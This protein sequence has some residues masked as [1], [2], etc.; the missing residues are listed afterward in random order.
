[1]VHS[2]LANAAL[3]RP[4]SLL[5]RPVPWW[6]PGPIVIIAG[7]ELA[8][9]GGNLRQMLQDLPHGA[10]KNV[11]V[12]MRG[13]K[14]YRLRGEGHMSHVTGQGPHLLVETCKTWSFLEL[15]LHLRLQAKPL[16]T[17]NAKTPSPVILYELTN[18]GSATWLPLSFTRIKSVPSQA[19][20]RACFLDKPEQQKMLSLDGH[21]KQLYID[22]PQPWNDSTRIMLCDLSKN[23][24]AY[25]VNVHAKTFGVH[26]SWSCAVL[27]Y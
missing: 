26:L 8:V 5:S 16:N 2:V 25:S 4:P 13:P 11:N 19:F 14:N 20:G 17:S 3:T 18:I 23:A 27:P 21:I 9:Q 22:A 1:M 7:E 24:K 6:R 12:P 15:K 10:C